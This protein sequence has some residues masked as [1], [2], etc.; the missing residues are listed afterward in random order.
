MI[1]TRLIAP[2]RVNLF[3]I[4]IPVL[5]VGWAAGHF[6]HTLSGMTG[7]ANALLA[8]GL[9]LMLLSIALSRRAI[10]IK[11]TRFGLMGLGILVI[12]LLVIGIAGLL[13][14]VS[15]ILEQKALRETVDDDTLGKRAAP[16]SFG[17][18]SNGFRND[19]VPV[20]ADIVAIGDSQTWGANADRRHTWPAILSQLANRPVYNMSRGGYGA[21]QYWRLSQ[22]AM[23]LS[24]KVMVVGVYFGNDLWDAYHAVYTDEQYQSLRTSQDKS[25]DLYKDTVADAIVTATNEFNKARRDYY[26]KRYPGVLASLVMFSDWYADAD[27]VWGQNAG[28]DGDTFNNGTLRTVFTT[29]YRF[30][31]LN[32]DD[33]RIAEGL[34]LTK[35]RLRQIKQDADAAHIRLIVLLIPTKEG[36]FA[37]VMTTTARPTYR[38]LIDMEAQDR[39]DISNFLEGAKIEYVDALPV[40]QQA[41]LQNVQIYPANMDGHPNAQGYARI[42]ALVFDKIKTGG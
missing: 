26:Q 31:P 39:G 22:E 40:L 1:P 30:L 12:G 38:Q 24:P 36:V 6:E 8:A 10:A 42:A 14:T 4:S 41:I 33:A 34:R 18:D 3:F 2:I 29:T 27:Y 19:S 16:N 9:L 21:V 13:P 5:L 25:S 32:R 35:D 15:I 11:L 23:K 37:P 28:Q 17:I 7:Y 20:Q